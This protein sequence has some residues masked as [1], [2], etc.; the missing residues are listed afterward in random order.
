MMKLSDQ[1]RRAIKASQLS[2]YR[3]CKIIGTD[4]SRLSRF[5]TGKPI[6]TDFL[7][8]LAELLGLSIKVDPPKKTREPVR[9]A[10]KRG[11]HG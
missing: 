8:Q 10:P 11:K 5:M 3:I 7:D 2:R 4:E 6:K 9:A 1:V